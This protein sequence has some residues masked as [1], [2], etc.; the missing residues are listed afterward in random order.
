MM[1]SIALGCRK[2]PELTTIFTYFTTSHNSTPLTKARDYTSGALFKFPRPSTIRQSPIS[3]VRYAS[4]TSSPSSSS[5]NSSNSFSYNPPASS[6]DW[7]SFFRLRKKR[8]LYQQCSSVGSGLASV[9]CGVQFL[10][11]SDFDALVSSFPLDPVISLGLITAV[12]GGLGWLLG[13]VAGTA[14]FN[15]TNRQF[16][17]QMDEKEKEFYKRL[18]KNRVDPSNSSMVNPVPDYYGEKISS[19]ADYRQWL[20]DCRAFNIKRI[21]YL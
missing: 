8:R 2:Q 4:G 13:P 9:S 7:N 17:A 12:F 10:T 6:L 3:F 11:T 18:R 21:T 14:L 16:R 5:L 1:R 20:K 15:L 19:V